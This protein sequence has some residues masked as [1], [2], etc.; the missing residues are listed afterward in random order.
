MHKM[1][2]MTTAARSKAAMSAWMLG[3]VLGPLVLMSFALYLTRRLSP[4]GAV[5]DYVGLVVSVAGGLC[6]LLRLSSDVSFISRTWLTVLYV[7]AASGLLM[8]YTVFFV[9]VMFGHW[10]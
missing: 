7:P 8:L 6:C 3:T 4:V 5:W 9:G 2:A 1:T 10:S